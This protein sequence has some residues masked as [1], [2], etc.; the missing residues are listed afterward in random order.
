MF[1]RFTTDVRG[2]VLATAQETARRRGEARIGSDHILVGVVDSGN[3]TALA[4]G[5]TPAV[6]EAALDRLDHTAL[7]AIGLGADQRLLARPRRPRPGHLPFTRGAKGALQRSLR[8]A[9]DRG[10]RVI[11]TDHVLAAL[12]VGGHKDAAVRL[13]RAC[14]VDPAELE[15]AV[16]Q[17]M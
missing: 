7:G 8:I 1:E 12:A 10:D 17:A 13:L 9:V 14:G 2:I 16:R 11:T 15:S 6:L 5:L 3:A 4:A